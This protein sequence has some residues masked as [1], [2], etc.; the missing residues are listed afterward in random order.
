M[1]DTLGI[2]KRKENVVSRD[3]TRGATDLLEEYEA[4]W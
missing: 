1:T 4:L 3:N 2:K